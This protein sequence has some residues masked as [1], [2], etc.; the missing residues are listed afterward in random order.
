VAVA[1]ISRS[2]FALIE[3]FERV[4]LLVDSQGAITDSTSAR[5][6]EDGSPFY[7][8]ASPRNHGPFRPPAPTPG[9]SPAALLSRLAGRAARLRLRC[10]VNPHDSRSPPAPT[11]SRLARSGSHG[12]SRA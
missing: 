4:H 6:E 1:S 3:T 8:P 7:G 12:S 11:P 5:K 2:V 10:G 9:R